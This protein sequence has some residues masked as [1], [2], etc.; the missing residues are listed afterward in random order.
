MRRQMLAPVLIDEEVFRAI[1]LHQHCNNVVHLLGLSLLLNVHCHRL[2]GPCLPRI[3]SRCIILPSLIIIILSGTAI[4]ILAQSHTATHRML[5]GRLFALSYHSVCFCNHYSWN[6]GL[7]ILFRPTK[8]EEGSRQNLKSSS[9]TQHSIFEFLEPCLWL[10]RQSTKEVCFQ[11][12]ILR[13]GGCKGGLYKRSTILS[14]CFANSVSSCSPFLMPGFCET[15]LR[16]WHGL[17]EKESLPLASL[18]KCSCWWCL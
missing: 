10:S 13:I 11:T 8:I 3:D 17:E 6:F 2:W 7:L 4:R 14:V 16:L 9:D 15:E 12:W 1:D 5:R 18:Q